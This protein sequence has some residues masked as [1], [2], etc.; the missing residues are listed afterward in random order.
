MQ[1]GLSLGMKMPM[2]LS[3]V[4]RAIG[5]LNKYGAD[6]HLYLPGVGMVSGK[7][8]GN[9]LESTFT[10]LATVDGAVG[11]VR[12]AEGSIDAT[13]P[14]AANRPIL[15]R[16]AVNLL[17]YSQDFTNAVWEKLAAG[18]ATLAEGGN[19]CTQTVRQGYAYSASARTVAFEVRRA[20]TESASHVRATSNDTNTWNT[21]SSTKLLLTSEWQTVVCNVPANMAVY[22][23]L[24][25]Y[26]ALGDID[27]DCVG[28][29][30]V[31]AGGLFQGTYTAAQI[32][33]L[34]GIPLTTTAPASTA[35]GPYF[36]EF[37]GVND[38]L[39]LSAPLFQ[40]ADDFAIVVGVNRTSRT[41]T[42]ESAFGV[43]GGVS[44][45]SLTSDSLG[46]AYFSVFNDTGTQFIAGATAGP[47]W[48]A[49]YV[50]TGLKRTG[51]MRHRL[52]SSEQTPTRTPTGN[53]TL[54]TATIGKVGASVGDSFVTGNIYPIIAIKGT[55]SDADLLTLE[56]FIG[57][58][59]GVTI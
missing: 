48:A 40:M 6:A 26:N 25:K 45:I 15:R 10:N 13:Q 42:W 34:G 36:W 1:I 33:A 39:A 20:S 54:T 23:I 2:C 27:A 14:T 8:A 55:V 18:T 28:S 17:T 4:Q 12:D 43:F 50:Q 16:G 11:G 52:N 24:G 32:Q 3:L 30:V 41:A 56:R 29:F 49:P 37:D 19:L 5:I 22:A 51:I 47:V 21:G 9:Y 59:S 46:R 44:F 35:L 31:R 7:T 38:S 58:L 53:F 57:S